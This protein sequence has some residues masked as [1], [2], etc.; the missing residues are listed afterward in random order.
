MMKT[1]M[2]LREKYDLHMRI[3]R[4]KSDDEIPEKTKRL[5]EN[6]RQDTIGVQNESKIYFIFNDG[7]RELE[8]RI[9]QWLKNSGL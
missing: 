3:E 9:D 4:Y 8:S 7:G 2:V 1:I 6:R 5:S